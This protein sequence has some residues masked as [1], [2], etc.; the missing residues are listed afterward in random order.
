MTWKMH[1]VILKVPMI[2]NPDTNTNTYVTNMNFTRRLALKPGQVHPSKFPY[3]I[4]NLHKINLKN[5][6]D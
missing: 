4:D 2:N 5:W 3:Y 1:E 6:I